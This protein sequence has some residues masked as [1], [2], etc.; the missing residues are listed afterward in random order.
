MDP[1]RRKEARK[2]FKPPRRAFRKPPEYR[3]RRCSRCQRLTELTDD[4]RCGSC[5]IDLSQAFVR[6]LCDCGEWKTIM[7]S[8]N[9]EMPVRCKCEQADIDR[10]REQ[11]VSAEREAKRRKKTIDDAQAL[12]ARECWAEIGAGCNLKSNELFP[13]CYTCQRPAIATGRVRAPLPDYDKPIT[14][15]VRRN[16]E[17]N[18]GHIPARP[19]SRHSEDTGELP[20]TSAP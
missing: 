3:K 9:R 6:V 10:R 4:W 18:K 15:T 11:A 17:H 5:G 16:D 7:Y 12:K 8:Y 14:T 1:V 13:H 2:A 19:D 20:P